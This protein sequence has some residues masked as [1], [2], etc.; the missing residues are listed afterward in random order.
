MSIEYK[1]NIEMKIRAQPM[2]LGEGSDHWTNNNII[3]AKSLTNFSLQR[4]LVR[5]MDAKQ[6]SILRI[7]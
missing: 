4:V 6:D 5:E 2:K 1:C 3:I 7:F